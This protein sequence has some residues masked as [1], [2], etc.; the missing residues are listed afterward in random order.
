MK[1][2]KHTKWLAHLF[3]CSCIAACSETSSNHF[4]PSFIQ[5]K[6]VDGSTGPQ[7]SVIPKGKGVVGGRNFRSFQNES[8]QHEVVAKQTFAVGVN[9]VTFDEFD[10]YCQSAKAQCPSDEGWGR[11]SQ[12]VINVS[13]EE[14]NAYTQWLSQQTGEV[15]RLPSEAEWEYAARGGQ[16]TP[17]WWGDDY[18]QGIDHCDR[19]LGNC[20]EGTAIAQ[21]G[22]AGRFKSNPFGLY[23]VTSNVNEWVLDCNSPNHDGADNTMAA[24][25]TGDCQMRIAKGASWRNPQ[26]YVHLSKRMGLET[27]YRNASIGFRVL[28]EI[29]SE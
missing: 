23:D 27:Y 8:P 15:Y 9:E 2:S 13:W 18:I 20:P 12:P 3:A 24:N 26:P 10:R 7:L 25:L 16:S 19:D 11:G 4:T 21:S 29:K 5:D 6:L 17:F 14:A 1:L 28:R 22:P